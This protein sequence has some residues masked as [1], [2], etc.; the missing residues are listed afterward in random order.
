MPRARINTVVV[1]LFDEPILAARAGI[2][3]G[4]SPLCSLAIGK[5][6]AKC[7]ERKPS[8]DHYEVSYIA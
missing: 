8:C 5:S 3:E 6:D 2:P 1:T 4:Y 7:E